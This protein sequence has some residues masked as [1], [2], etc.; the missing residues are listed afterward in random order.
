MSADLELAKSIVDGTLDLICPQMELLICPSYHESALSGSGVVRS[1]DRGQLYFKLAAPFQGTPHPAL[2]RT[3]PAGAVHE[4][5]DHVMLRAVDQNGYEWRSNWLLLELRFPTIQPS[6][7]IRH[8]LESLICARVVPRKS[9]SRLTIHIPN[10]SDLMFDQSTTKT[11]KVGEAEVSRGWSIDHHKRSFQDVDL[12]FHKGEDA[13]LTVHATRDCPIMPDWP[14]VLCHALEFACARRARPAVVVREFNDRRNTGLFSGPF[15]QYR[16]L[17]PP[18]IHPREPSEAEPFWALI[19]RFF[20]YASADHL[21]AE[22]FLSELEGIR[23]GASGSVQTACL[24]L[25]VG[26]ESLCD[27]LLPQIPP[28]TNA[29]ELNNL[30]CH[31]RKWDGDETLGKRA[32]NLISNLRSVRTADRLYAWASNHDVDR[33][34]VDRWK[35]LRNPSVHGA[36][37]S[38]DQTLFDRYY[39]AVELLYRIV[40]WAIEFEGEILATSMH[41]WG[42]DNDSEYQNQPS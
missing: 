13:W 27:T 34:L 36:A 25:A 8:N 3:R 40:T 2:Q 32:I 35:E 19:E 6:W 7:L 31:I 12:A 38:E 41:G 1:N 11:V 5:H 39:A 15:W 29:N 9:K 26:I 20:V 22:R 33:T 18:P 23:N 10:Q 16:S 30:L 4:E 37:L 17:M 28:S 14:G 21:V 24:T 42:Q